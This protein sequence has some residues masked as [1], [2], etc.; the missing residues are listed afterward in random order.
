M[1][2][3]ANDERGLQAWFGRYLEWLLISPNGKHEHDAKNNHGSWYAAQTAAYAIYVGDTVRARAIVEEVKT[4]IGEQIT[5]A[6]DQPAELERTRS[7]HYSAFNVEALSRVAEI[8]RQLGV[9]LWRYQAPS[10]GSLKKAIDRLVPYIASG[11]KWPGEQ[12]DPVELDL[13]VIHLR[14]ARTVFGDS[15]YVAALRRLPTALTE[16]DKSALLYPDA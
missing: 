5:P 8:G 11:A 16:T 9:D 15:T 12:I 6:G 1:S 14:R 2:W 4:R 13:L 3:T 7:M 10:G